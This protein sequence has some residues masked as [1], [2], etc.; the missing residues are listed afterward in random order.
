MNYDVKWFKKYQPQLLGLANTDEGR[1]LLDIDHGVPTVIEIAPWYVT[2]LIGQGE[3]QT[4][5]YGKAWFYRYVQQRWKEIGAAMDWQANSYL[6]R[7]RGKLLIPAGGA[8]LTEYPDADAEG[9]TVDGKIGLQGADPGD[10]MTWAELQSD[11]GSGLNDPG[12]DDDN[13]QNTMGIFFRTGDGWEDFQRLIHTYNT[14]AI[15]TNVVSAAV[16]SFVATRADTGFSEVT[17]SVVS[18]TTASDTGLAKGDWD[19]FG[20]TVFGSWEN[21]G[22]TVD[23]STYTDITFNSDGRAHINRSGITKI[24]NRWEAD[25]A[26]SDPGTSTQAAGGINM[27]AADEG[28]SVRP[29]LVVTHA[30]GSDTDNLNGIALADIQD[31]NDVTAANGQA[32]NGVDF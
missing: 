30:V 25:R 21:D 13:A 20:T 31:F 6:A 7:N 18:S 9:D 32:I 27:Y 12:F 17:H 14:A 5:F 28:G 29:K 11:N 2:W 1:D 3:Y 16:W 8:V 24:G 22:I 19:G 15:G 23:S 26:N 10:H 4:L